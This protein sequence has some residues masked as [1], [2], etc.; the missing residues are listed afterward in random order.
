MAITRDEA[1]AALS[2]IESTQRRGMTLRGYQVGGPILM[3]WS[4]IWGAGYL[5]MGLESPQVWLWVWLSLNLVGMVGSLVL[6]RPAKARSTDMP[7]GAAWRLLGGSLSLMVFSLC[8]FMIMQPADLAAA[9][10]YPGLLIGAIYAVIGFWSAMRYA[11]VGG[12]MFGLTLVG[13]VFFRPWLP[14]WMAAASGA[15]FLSGVWLWRR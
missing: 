10:A 1:A 13:Y 11:A 15:L 14:F 12:L 2:D 4:V 8:V 7:T 9:M 3:L 6:A 5:A